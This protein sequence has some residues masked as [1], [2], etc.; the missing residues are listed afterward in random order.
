MTDNVILQKQG[1]KK[2]LYSNISR[3]GVF[4]PK[5]DSSAITVKNLMKST[6]EAYY[7]P[8]T[9]NIHKLRLVPRN[10]LQRSTQTCYFYLFYLVQSVVGK[11]LPCGTSLPD[12]AYIDDLIFYHN[13]SDRLLLRKKFEFTHVD[14]IY[15][16]RNRKRSKKHQVKRGFLKADCQRLR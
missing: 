12:H 8:A 5:F 16:K 10:P 1:L 4:L 13:P 15:K 2:T 9:E 6:E 11:R 7:T 14:F 3:G